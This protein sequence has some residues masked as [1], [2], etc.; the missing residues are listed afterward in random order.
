MTE[1]Q[2][3]INHLNDYKKEVGYAFVPDQHQHWMDGKKLMSVTQFIHQ[4]KEP[5]DA[6][7]ISERCSKDTSSIYYKIEPEQIRLYWNLRTRL[8]TNKH[9][10]VERWLKHN[11]SKDDIFTE[12]SYFEEHNIIPE[13][14]VSEFEFCS[15][16]YLLGGIA[17]IVQFVETDDKIKIYISDVK[18]TNEVS[19][20]NYEGFV[21]QLL[22]LS[23][24]LNMMLFDFES[25]K[26]IVIRPKYIIHIKPIQKEVREGLDIWDLEAFEPPLFINVDNY[27]DFIPR[28]KNLFEKRLEEIKMAT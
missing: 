24:L 4:D 13:N 2:R 11:L 27:S 20:W 7:K 22:T 19:D 6:I 8:G 26:K 23:K 25:D 15:E 3:I 21:R 5:F 18:T 16:K 9:A 12:R 14:T 1:K 17:D 10:Q 28:L